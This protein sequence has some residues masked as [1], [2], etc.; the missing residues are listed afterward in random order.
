MAKKVAIVG[1]SMRYANMFEEEGWE[2]I[3]DI[4]K[5]DLLLFTGG[6]DVNPALYGERNVGS[7]CNPTRDNYEIK[8]YEGWV[9][10][11]KMAG[12]CRGGQFLNVMNGGKMWQDV[13]NHTN[14]HTALFFE[15]TTVEVTSTHHQM[16]RPASNAIILATAPNVCTARYSACPAQLGPSD[17]DVE[18]CFYPDTMSLCFQ[19]HPEIVKKD[20][21]CRRVFFQLLED[22]L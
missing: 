11:V 14:S 19:P 8:I 7:G 6:E 13:N 15:H 10:K 18:V 2:V 22:V 3:E 4:S 9:G 21:P 1:F 20:H 12:I 5:A 16:M 17:D